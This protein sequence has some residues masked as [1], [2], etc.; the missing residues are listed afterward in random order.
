MSESFTRFD[1]NIQRVDNLCT[2]LSRQK[3]VLNDRQ[4]KK[5]IFSE[6]LWYFSIPH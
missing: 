6:L 3:R 2:L 5:L 4:S 1:R